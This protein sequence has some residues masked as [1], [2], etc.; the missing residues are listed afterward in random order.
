MM[1][2]LAALLLALTALVGLRA[3]DADTTIYFVNIYAGPEI[4]ELDG[5]A[6]IVVDIE[7]Q[8]PQSYN[9]GVFDFDAPNFV[10]RFVKGETDYMAVEWPAQPFIDAYRRQ[11]RRVVAHE[12]NF[13]SAAKARLVHLLRENVKPENAVYRYNY[14]KDNC[15]TRPLRAVELAAAD[16]IVLA[17]APFEA[18]SFLRPTF[19]NVMRAH[20]SAYPWYQFGIDL[21]LGGGIDYTL[22]R[23]EL[24]FT[25]VELDGML[26]GATVGGRPL[27][28]T[29]HVWVD[30]APD[31]AVEAPTPW[32]AHPLAVCWAVFALAAVLSVA[33]IRRRRLSRWFDTVLFALIGI[34]GLVLTFLIFVSVHEAT[35]PNW[36]Y[37]WCNPFALLVP[38][39]IWIKKAKNVL[40]CYQIANF[41][42]LLS[43]IA[44]WAFIPQSA[45]AAFFPLIGAEMLRSAVYVTLTL[46]E[47]KNTK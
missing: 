31:A 11:G 18:Q 23:R 45:N 4:F 41:A 29:T 17:P 27:V 6:A 32:Y 8:R 16:S 22:D 24:A 25:P 34:N 40:F 9:F 38:A 10:Y 42:V 14:V 39:L 2:R 5:H 26:A 44:L 35:S 13:D 33:D 15:S 3:A 1:K 20:H 30:T 12:L 47:K 43:V 36:L 19:R 28:K 37:L 7:G 46:A 21:A